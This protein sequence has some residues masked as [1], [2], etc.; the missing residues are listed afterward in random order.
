VYNN[1]G[2]AVTLNITGGGGTPTVRNG[3]GASTTV[4]N[5]VS[6]V[7]E[8][9]VSGSAYRIELASDGT[10]IDSGTATGGDITASIEYPGT[11]TAINVIVRKSS[12]DP[13]YKPFRTGATLTASGANVFVNQVLDRVIA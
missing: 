7:L 10:E 11:P 13:K 8:N 1:S 9:V 2:G 6:I 4:S 12:A 3:T 5:S